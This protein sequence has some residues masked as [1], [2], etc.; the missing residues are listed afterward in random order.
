MP[1]GGGAP[2]PP[3]G[4]ARMGV[5]VVGRADPPGF[6][7]SQTHLLACLQD[8]LHQEHLVGGPLLIVY[9]V[10]CH[11]GSPGRSI[12]GGWDFFHPQRNS[13]SGYPSSKRSLWVQPGSCQWRVLASGVGLREVVKSAAGLGVRGPQRLLPSSSFAQET[14]WAV[15]PPGASPRPGVG[16]HLQEKS[17]GIPSGFLR[18]WAGVGGGG[19]IQ[20]EWEGRPSGLASLHGSS[21]G[22]QLPLG[23]FRLQYTF[24]FSNGPHRARGKVLQE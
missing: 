5:G 18:L 2:P 4:P 1:F 21:G 11:R 20:V 17:S 6:P 10:L 12:M 14:V 23:C 19:S 8:F 13:E 15:A 24:P 3:P 7:I 22:L 16:G 9:A